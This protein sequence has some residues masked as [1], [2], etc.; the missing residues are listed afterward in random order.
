MT[1][2]ALFDTIASAS[3]WVVVRYQLR[4]GQRCMCG[5]V[6]PGLPGGPD[7]GFPGGTVSPFLPMYA[8]AE[9][10]QADIDRDLKVTGPLPIALDEPTRLRDLHFGVIASDSWSA[11]GERIVY[12][13]GDYTAARAAYFM[14]KGLLGE[15]P[16]YRV[17]IAC[18]PRSPGV[19]AAQRWQ[20]LWQDHARPGDP[21]P[22]GIGG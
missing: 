4:P 16:R 3:E 5:P 21:A 9:D 19:S 14:A 2:L 10:A 20:Q 12:D 1:T 11:G 17:S 6:G 18:M 13:G 15:H 22:R 7:R 8:T